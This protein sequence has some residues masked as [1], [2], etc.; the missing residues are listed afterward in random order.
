[1]PVSDQGVD[2]NRYQVTPRTLVFIFDSDERVLLLKGAAD[3]RLWAG[4]YNGIGG[5]IEPGEDILEAAQ[6]ELWEEA[7]IVEALD[8]CGQIM[9]DVSPE[10]GVTIFIFRGSYSGKLLNASE[11]GELAW[12]EVKDLSH[13]PL[14]E[15]LATILPLVSNF[16][17]GDT[18]IIGNYTYQQNGKLIISIR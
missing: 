2:V 3:K 17:V 8:Y 10:Q 9:V 18:P 16:K 15:D 13:L 12:V 4:L 14:V 6:R 7:G 11:E 1:M 5:H